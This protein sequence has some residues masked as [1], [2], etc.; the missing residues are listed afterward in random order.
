MFLYFVLRVSIKINTEN[1]NTEKLIDESRVHFVKIDLNIKLMRR[2]WRA[3]HAYD[4]GA[5]YEQVLRIY[6]NGK[7]KNNIQEHLKISDKVK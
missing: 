2:W 6:F 4:T 1:F 5:T 7:S 3:L